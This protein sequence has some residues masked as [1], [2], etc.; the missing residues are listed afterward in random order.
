MLPE[1][2]SLPDMKAVVGFSWPENIFWKLLEVMLRVASTSLAALPLPQDP[3]PF[4]RSRNQVVFWSDREKLN[5][6]F[7]FLTRSSLI[8][9]A[10]WA[11]TASMGSPGVAGAAAALLPAA[12]LAAM[13]TISSALSAPPWWSRNSS[14]KKSGISEASV[15]PG[16]RY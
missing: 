5:T 13:S 1:I 3:A 10:I 7:V 14:R 16:P 6:A 4:L 15:A 2:F 12:G 9:G 8:R 11:N